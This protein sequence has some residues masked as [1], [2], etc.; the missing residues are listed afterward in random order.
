MVFLCR[1]HIGCLSETCHVDYQYFLPFGT[2]IS[3]A[4]LVRFMFSFSFSEYRS[5]LWPVH[6]HLILFIW[7]H[8]LLVFIC[9]HGFPCHLEFDIY[10]PDNS[11]HHWLFFHQSLTQT[12]PL[13]HLVP[14]N[15][16]YDSEES[17]WSLRSLPHLP[18][19]PPWF[20]TIKILVVA[21]A[22]NLKLECD[23]FY[24]PFCNI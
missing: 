24:F 15:N 3:L 21:K 10:S 4:T 6:S 11:F 14:F 16:L 7:I 9:F 8:C 5:S 20:L 12:F 17:L 23:I 1:L 18:S 22:E 2:M 13:R 19:F